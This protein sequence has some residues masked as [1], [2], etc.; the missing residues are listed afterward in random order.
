MGIAPIADLN[1]ASPG[2]FSA[3]ERLLTTVPMS[4]WKAYL[5]WHTA[6]LASP[7]LS[8]R[9]RRTPTSTFFSKTLAGAQQL[10]P[11]W[12]RCVNRVDRHLGEALGEVYVAKYFSADTRA[13][14]LRMVKQIETAMEEDINS[15]AWMSRGH[16]EAGAG[17]AAR[18][19]Q[20]DR[21]S[22]AVA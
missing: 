14:T 6:R 20:Q 1:I 17:E 8:S 3:L 16:E 18:R 15:L 2:Y 12:K 21:P 11:R 7:Y 10:Q 9:V 22:R 5:R 13:R 19:D 4:D